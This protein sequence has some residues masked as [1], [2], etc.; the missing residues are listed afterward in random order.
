MK[1]KPLFVS[2]V[3]SDSSAEALPS[4]NAHSDCKVTFV[5]VSFCVNSSN[6]AS[7]FRHAI[8]SLLISVLSAYILGK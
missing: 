1:R 6:S 4:V 2:L 3:C 8:I 5:S 7:F